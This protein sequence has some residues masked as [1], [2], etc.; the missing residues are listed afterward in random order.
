VFAGFFLPCIVLFGSIET[1]VLSWL[2]YHRPLGHRDFVHLQRNNDGLRGL[3]ANFIRYFL[4]NVSFGIDGNANQSGL[5]KFLE[6]ACRKLLDFFHLNNVG[7][8]YA[9]ASNDNTLDLTKKGSE[10]F[11][12]FGLIGFAALLISSFYIWR[13]TFRNPHWAVI[14][15]GFATLA[16]ISFIVGWMPWNARFLCLSFVL[17]GVAM[18]II[19]FGELKRAFWLRQFFGVLIIWSVFT[20]PFLCVD[21]TPSDLG[22]AFYAREDL[23]FDQRSWDRQVY[24]DVVALRT[25]EKGKWFLIAGEDSYVLPFLGLADEPWILTPRWEQIANFPEAVPLF[26]LVLNRRIPPT[27]PVEIVRQYVDD[28]YILRVRHD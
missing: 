13:P 23:T 17:F 22:R 11:S 26:V 2:I 20:L 21:R 16:L 5:A 9:Y 10:Y 15:S 24:D 6:N 8:A 7:Y 25:K 14:A 3:S 1:Y 4:Q 28:T 19:V 12:D 18:A 27:L